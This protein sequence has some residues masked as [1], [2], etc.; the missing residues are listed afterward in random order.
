MKYKSPTISAGSGKVAG[1]VYSR[2]KGGNYIRQYVKPVN[3]KTSFQ[4]V[5]QNATGNLQSRFANTLT[6]AQRAAWA[7]WAAN[8][9]TVDALGNAIKLTAQNWYIAMNSLRVQSSL[10][11]I[12]PAPTVF[13]LAAVTI[14]VPTIVAA[15]TTVSLAYTNTDAWA[16]EVG[17]ALLL[18][19]SRPQNVTKNFFKGPYRFAGKVAGAGTPPTSPAVI[20]LPFVIGPVGSKMFF[21]AVAVRADGRPSPAVFLTAS[22]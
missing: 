20:T 6:T 22:A 15:G 16:G 12:D 10:S 14:P 19:A 21:K 3:P 11:I 18:Y 9:T 5:L 7:V 13:A 4:Q 2:N 1:L 8:V 17:G